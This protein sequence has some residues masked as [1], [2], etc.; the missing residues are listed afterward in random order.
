MKTVARKWK[1]TKVFHLKLV[2]VIS[3]TVRSG[4]VVATFPHN[5]KTLNS[6]RNNQNNKHLQYLM[7]IF[8]MGYHPL[9]TRSYSA[10]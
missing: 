8:H 1:K 4:A 2:K 3:D 10:V 9:L 5:S 7:V 6:Q